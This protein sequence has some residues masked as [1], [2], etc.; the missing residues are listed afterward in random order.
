M[1]LFKKAK[2]N[3]L[4]KKGFTLIEII[5]VLVI[6]AILAAAAIPSMLGFIEDAKGKALVAEARAAYIACQA[7]NTEERAAGT[8]QANL[9][10][11]FTSTNTGTGADTVRVR[12]RLRTMLAPDNVPVTAFAANPTAA[13]IASECIITVVDGDFDANGVLTRIQF[14]KRVN[15]TRTATIVINPPNAATI[16]Y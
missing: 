14:Q 8:P 5:V 16:S 13:Q 11:G 3:I 15:A 10:A 9:V 1:N 7:I 12:N 4:N 2:A 6:L